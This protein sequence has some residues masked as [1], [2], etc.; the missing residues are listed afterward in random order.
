LRKNSGRE[1]AAY[2]LHRHVVMSARHRRLLQNAQRAFGKSMSMASRTRGGAAAT[3]L[4]TGA[5]GWVA[6]MQGAESGVCAMARR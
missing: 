1:A 5:C 6:R 2:L 3:L 4:A